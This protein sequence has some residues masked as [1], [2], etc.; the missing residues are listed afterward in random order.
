[1]LMSVIIY[2]NRY[3]Q[4]FYA[5]LF[6]TQLHTPAN[7]RG[8]I[9]ICIIF[10]TGWLHP[11]GRL[12]ERPSANQL[13]VLLKTTMPCLSLF[14]KQASVG[15]GMSHLIM[16]SISIILHWI[17]QQQAMYNEASPNHL[18]EY[19]KGMPCHTKQPSHFQTCLTVV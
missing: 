7:Q 16:T 2:C 10:T 17:P 4:L 13:L 6:C 3:S 12:L 5:Q 8:R 9:P 1:M 18:L 15:T 14:T 19:I 11:I